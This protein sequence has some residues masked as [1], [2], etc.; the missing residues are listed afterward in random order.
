VDLDLE[1]FFRVPYRSGVGYRVYDTNRYQPVSTRT[2]PP[3]PLP[4]GISLIVI[5]QKEGRVTVPVDFL[6]HAVPLLENALH[7][8]SPDLQTFFAGHSSRV[9]G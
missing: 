6:P 7:L 3:P 2:K 4:P 5:V 9:P 1:H 8:L